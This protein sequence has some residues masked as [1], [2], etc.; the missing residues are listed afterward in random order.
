VAG[1]SGIATSGNASS[2]GSGLNLFA[3]PVAVYQSCSRPL[4]SVQGRIPYDQLRMPA[5]WNF[6]FSLGKNFAVTERYHLIFSAEMLNVFNLVNFAAPSLSLNSPTNFGVFT[7]QF[8]QPRRFLLGL[9]FQ[10]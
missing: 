3:N 2:G 6:D 8:N 9:K 5:T 4:L 7:T 1:S 10:F